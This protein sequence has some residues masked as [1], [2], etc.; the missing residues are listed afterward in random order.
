MMDENQF[1]KEV[2]WCVEQLRLGMFNKNPTTQ[3][4]NTF[5]VEYHIFWP[6]R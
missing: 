4:S 1:R 2:N 5:V 3:Q 6:M